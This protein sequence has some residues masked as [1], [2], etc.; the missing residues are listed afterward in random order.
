MFFRQV[1]NLTLTVSILF[2]SGC[3]TLDVE[4]IRALAADSASFCAYSGISG[5]AGGLATGAAGGYG[6]ADFAFCRS[7][8]DGATVRLEADGS[9]SI[10]HK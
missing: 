2:S 9:L 7:N 6:Q 8:H 10:E 3:V 1:I 5:G 4:M